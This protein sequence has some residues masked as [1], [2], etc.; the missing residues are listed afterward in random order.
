MTSGRTFGQHGLDLNAPKDLAGADDDVVAVAI[1][2]GFSDGESEGC[3]FSHKSKFG[4][5]PAMF[6]I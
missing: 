2:P 5:F 1:S 4:E 3:G 6:A